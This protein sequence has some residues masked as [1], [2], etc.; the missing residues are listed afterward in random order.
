MGRIS[1]Q[2]TRPEM[3]VRSTL[4]RMGYR[5]RLHRKNLPGKPDIVLPK[6]G[7]AVFVHGCFWHGHKDC[8]EGHIPKSNARYW[9]PKLAKNKQRDIENVKK[10]R[11]S[12]WKCV[13]VWE[14]Q[15][16]NLSKLEERLREA[17]LSAIERAQLAGT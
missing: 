3:R 6:W 17:I 16:E 10:L 11:E 9:G 13:I 14:C 12:G 4:H 15:T 7:I 5:F 1:S 8:C 2:N